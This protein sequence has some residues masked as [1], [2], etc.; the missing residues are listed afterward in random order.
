MKAEKNA[1]AFILSIKWALLF[2][3]IDITLCRVEN[4]EERLR[5]TTK[6][7][8]KGYKKRTK[9]KSLKASTKEKKNKTSNTKKSTNKNVEE[10][11]TKV[12]NS[13][14]N[15][16]E[17]DFEF[18][19]EIE[20]S[21]TEFASSDDTEFASSDDTEFASDDTE[22]ASSDSV[23]FNGGG[24]KIEGQL[25]TAELGYDAFCLVQLKG[26]D[27]VSSE[28]RCNDAESDTNI[29]FYCNNGQIV[30]KR[31]G[32]CLA[33][34]DNVFWRPDVIKVNRCDWNKNYQ[35]FDKLDE[36]ERKVKSESFRGKSS[37][38]T[39]FRLKARSGNNHCLSARDCFFG[40]YVGADFCNTDPKYR[41]FFKDDTKS[42]FDYWS[43]K[44]GKDFTFPSLYDEAHDGTVASSIMYGLSTIRYDLRQGVPKYAKN[45]PVDDLKKYFFQDIQRPPEGPVT[46][47]EIYSMLAGIPDV[48]LPAPKEIQEWLGIWSEQQREKTSLYYFSDTI[49]NHSPL[50]FGI[51][52]EELSKRVSVWIKGSEGFGSQSD[53]NYFK[54]WKFKNEPCDFINQSNYRLG[55]QSTRVQKGYSLVADAVFSNIVKE[56][57]SLFLVDAYNSYKVYFFGHSMG[58]SI[59]T[60]LGYRLAL[61]LY[62]NDTPSIPKPISIVSLAAP[63]VGDFDFQKTFNILER[64]GFLRHLRM[65]NQEDWA[66]KTSGG[67]AP[68]LTGAGC[69]I[70]ALDTA[71]YVGI[72]VHLQYPESYIYYTPEYARVDYED[73]GLLVD[74]LSPPYNFI[75]A[76]NIDNCGGFFCP[77]YW[78]ATGTYM[79]MLILTFRERG[80]YLNDLYENWL[81]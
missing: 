39:E 60:L 46:L 58:G 12:E 14:T 51:F 62:E 73:I 28:V 47:Q 21:D 53:V 30:N 10:S 75:D 22:F 40:C 67:A 65:E 31:S 2:L 64:E 6:T 18:A 71:K 20:N 35:K 19:E 41:F 57:K 16:E 74:P 63:Q 49:P 4:D 72:D 13:N 52:V 11:N 70:D 42:R 54:D 38:R 66:P 79:A 7:Y 61:E 45:I 34:I 33:Y 68:G 32:Q 5:S 29:W 50:S 15:V 23:C 8:T 56:L 25:H 24:V 9:T 26:S 3:N 37:A 69:F 48:D 77:T 76:S 81:A 55:N 59:S 78:H 17:S 27:D 36:Q 80:L 1:I 43:E 44:E